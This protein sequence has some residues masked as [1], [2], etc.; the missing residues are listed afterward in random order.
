MRL[1]TTKFCG[2]VQSA[3]ISV[4]NSGLAK[5]VLTVFESCGNV[6]VIYRTDCYKDYCFL[7]GKLNKDPVS[8]DRWCR[9]DNHH[10][11]DDRDDENDDD[12]K[13]IRVIGGI[14]N[15]AN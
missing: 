2:D 6:Y 14:Q 1:F 8:T 11:C 10:G 13:Y 4:N 12:D 9:G 15:K 3:I 5:Y 7:C